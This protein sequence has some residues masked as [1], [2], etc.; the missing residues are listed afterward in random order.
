VLE[1][2]YGYS[3][4]SPNTVEVVAVEGLS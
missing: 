4:V 2:H 3:A 1:L